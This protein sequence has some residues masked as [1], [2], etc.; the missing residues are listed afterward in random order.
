MIP[1]L[2]FIFVLFFASGL[3]YFKVRNIS[4][5]IKLGKPLLINDN[6][7][8]RWKLMAKV[9]IGQSKMVRRPV[10]AIMHIFVY[11]GFIIVNI[12]MLEILIDGI[13]GTHRFFSFIGSLYPVLISSFEMTKGGANRITCS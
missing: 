8:R 11:V 2:I 10:A 1:S 13:F 4:R 9:A 6:K 7:I 12:E 5:E 3:F